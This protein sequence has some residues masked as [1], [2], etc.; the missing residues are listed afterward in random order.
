MINITRVTIDQPLY[1][2]VW[3]FAHREYISRLSADVLHKPHQFFAAMVEDQV[4]GCLGLNDN[5][6]SS[7]FL[8]D[9]R[10]QRLQHSWKP[11]VRAIDQSFFTVTGYTIAV[12]ALIAVAAAHS[13]CIGISKIAYAGIDV[14]CRTID[15]LGLEVT[16]LGPA[17]LK[18]VSEEMQQVMSVWHK[19][20]NPVVC[21]MDTHGAREI[22]LSILDRHKCRV[23]IDKSLDLEIFSRARSLA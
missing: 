19:Q 2:Q 18:L 20:F 23:Q 6:V 16:N 21:V 22:T 7:I 9:L 13:E 17:N 3:D 11:G 1:G 8:N 5:V 4:V 14:S 10:F 12:P 15:R